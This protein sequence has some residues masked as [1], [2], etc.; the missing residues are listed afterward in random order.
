MG[1]RDFLSKKRKAIY[2]WFIR[3]YATYHLLQESPKILWQKKPNGGEKEGK[4]ARCFF[5]K[6]RL[7]KKQQFGNRW[8]E[9]DPFP[10]GNA[11]F[12]FFQYN[13]PLKT[14]SSHLK[15]VVSNRNPKLPGVYFQGLLLLVSGRVIICAREL[16]IFGDFLWPTCRWGVAFDLDQPQTNPEK[17]GPPKRSRSRAHV[18]WAFFFGGAKRRKWVDWWLRVEGLM[19]MMMMMMIAHSQGMLRTWWMYHTLRSL[20]ICRFWCMPIVSLDFFV[21]GYT[22]HNT[23]GFSVAEPLREVIP[24]P[25]S[26]SEARSNF[27]RKEGRVDEDGWMDD[28]YL[29]I[30]THIYIYIYKSIY[31]YSFFIIFQWATLKLYVLDHFSFLS[32]TR[33]GR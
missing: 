31:L 26:S 23:W 20:W 32:W 30:Y 21:G 9:D 24:S 8:L 29:Y 6:S 10:F 1:G 11:Y 2:T 27:R 7:V 16:M 18:T 12:S 22:Q 5:G 25:Q 14:N 19:M 17:P 33:S 3:I 15:M 28:I 4:S 13:T